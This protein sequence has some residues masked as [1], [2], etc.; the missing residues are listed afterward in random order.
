MEKLNGLLK[1]KSPLLRKSV[2]GSMPEKI[3]LVGFAAKPIHN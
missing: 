1:Q 3:N 2:N